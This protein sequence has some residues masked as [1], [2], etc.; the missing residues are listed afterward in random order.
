MKTATDYD[1]EMHARFAAAVEYR[2]SRTGKKM[3]ERDKHH[4][5]T[6]WGGYVYFF[7]SR[8]LVD[9]TYVPG[10]VKI[11]QTRRLLERFRTLNAAAPYGL[12]MIGLIVTDKYPLVEIELHKRFS[13]HRLNGEWFEPSPEILMFAED[14]RALDGYK[15]AV[16]AWPELL[17]V[18]QKDIED[19]F[20]T[21]S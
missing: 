4:L 6:G 13:M 19:F 16:M 9:G 20:A 18:A 17:P 3:T 1:N 2:E 10:A 11:G 21:T 15:R 8:S 14:S 12:S 5:G 7:Q